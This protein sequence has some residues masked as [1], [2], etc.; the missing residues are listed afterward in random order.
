MKF[1]FID[2]KNRHPRP[3]FI[4]SYTEKKKFVPHYTDV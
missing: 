3:E 2:I 4:G 1:K